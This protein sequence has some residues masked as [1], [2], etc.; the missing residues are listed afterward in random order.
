MDEVQFSLLSFDSFLQS[1]LD[2]TFNASLPS[3]IQKA[4]P[5]PEEDTNHNG[6]KCPALNDEQD[7]RHNKKDSPPGNQHHGDPISNE[8]IFPAWQL[9]VDET[10]A[11]NFVHQIDLQKLPTCNVCL[12]FHMRGSCHKKCSSAATH[13]PADQL[14]PDQKKAMTNFIKAAREQFAKSKHKAKNKDE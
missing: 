3:A 4:L 2:G 1:I 13:V 10:Y 8:S 14:S 7:N 5:K 11:E 12:N 9:E 6:N